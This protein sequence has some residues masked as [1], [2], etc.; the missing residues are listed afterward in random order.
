MLK[1]ILI[2]LIVFSAFSS[3]AT[4]NFINNSDS[5]T[6]YIGYNVATFKKGG[7]IKWGV[8]QTTPLIQNGQSYTIGM[9]LKDNQKIYVQWAS[10]I[11]QNMGWAWTY[12]EGSPK[13]VS[14]CYMDNQH[15]TTSYLPVYHYKDY[16][17]IIVM[18]VQ[19]AEQP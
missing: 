14:R 12:C 19:C 15:T 17:P 7:S 10:V 8:M 18:E 9:G 1:S 11:D 4:F 13:C 5:M 2:F 3:A 16:P 6:V